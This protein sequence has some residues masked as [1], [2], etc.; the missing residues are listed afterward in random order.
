MSSR[1]IE[2][3]AGRPARSYCSAL[4]GMDAQ[5]HVT[6]AC[7]SRGSSR[8][9]SSVLYRFATQCSI[10]VSISVRLTLVPAVVH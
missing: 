8:F 7:D 2:V 4:E 5:G 1:E 10:S 6:G 3:E 9:S